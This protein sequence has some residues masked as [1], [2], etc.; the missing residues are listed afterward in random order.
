MA[1]VAFVVCFFLQTIELVTAENSARLF[2]CFSILS[3]CSMGMLKLY[4]LRIYRKIWLHMLAQM[5]KLEKHVGH[6]EMPEEEYESDDDTLDL[7]VFVKNYTQQFESTS[8]LL[9]KIYRSTVTGFITSVFV[10]HALLKGTDG[11]HILPCWSGFDHVHVAI[12]MATILMEFIASIYCVSVHLAFDRSAA[13]VMIFVK[14][15]F[16]LLRRYCENIAG[17]GRKCNI[18]NNRDRRALYRIKYCHQRTLILNDIVEKLGKLLKNVMGIYYIQVTLT[19]CSVAI[20]LKME[21]LSLTELFS[22]VQYLGATLTQLFLF[23]YFGSAVSDASTISLGQGPTGSSYWCISPRVRCHLALL[24]IGTAQPRRLRAGPFYFLDLTS[25][26]MIVRAAY[27]CYAC[28]G[29]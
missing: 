24:A 21:V 8:T 28:L 12:Y 25:F 20:R 26:T 6:N 2:E 22:L 7:T 29:K 4:F 10:E 5:R 16:L 17:K 1:T 15:Q 27:S 23:C 9:S 11:W 18:S 14:G 19:M 13:G 3:F